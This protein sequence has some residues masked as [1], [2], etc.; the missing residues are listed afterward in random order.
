ML[1]MASL[2]G[3]I[4]LVVLFPAALVVLP[5]DKSIITEPFVWDAAPTP[6]TADVNTPEFSRRTVHF[7]SQGLQLEGWLYTPKAGS[8]RFVLPLACTSIDGSSLTCAAHAASRILGWR[9]ASAEQL[10]F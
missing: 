8:S 1:S 2:F 5:W 7:P 4:P 9:R 3:L 6:S 10:Q